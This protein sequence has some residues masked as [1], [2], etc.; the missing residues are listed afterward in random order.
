MIQVH[1]LP[2]SFYTV[3]WGHGMISC[4]GNDLIICYNSG[5]AVFFIIS[6]IVEDQLFLFRQLLVS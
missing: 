2:S 3:Q 5:D 1:F 6:E 4:E